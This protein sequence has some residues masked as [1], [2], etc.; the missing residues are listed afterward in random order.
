MTDGARPGIPAGRYAFRP[1]NASA[2]PRRRLRL[3]PARRG[4]RAGARSSRATPRRLLVLDRSR[5]AALQHATFREHRLSGCGRATCW[6]STTLASSRPACGG[7][8][9]GGGAAEVLR[10]ATAARGPGPMGGAGAT[11][12]PPSGRRR[13]HAAERRPAR[14][15][16]AA[17]P[18]APGPSGSTATHTPSWPPP[19]RCRCRRTSTT[20]PRLPIAT[21]PSTRSRPARPRRRPPASTSRRSSWPRWTPMA[22]RRASAS[23]STSGSTR[24]GRSRASS[25]TS[26]T[27]TASGTRCPPPPATR[28]STRA[29]GGRVVAVGTTAVRVLETAARTDADSGWTDLYV[30]PP[31][32]F[33]AVDA[34]VTNFHLPRSSLLLLVTAFV[35]AGM[36]DAAT[37]LEA[38]DALL[39]A[40]RAAL[41]E[42]VSVLQLRRR[43]AD[44]LT[45][46]PGRR[47][48]S[49]RPPSPRRRA[50]SSSS[51]SPIG[52][53]VGFVIPSAVR[54]RPRPSVS[55]RSMA[56][57][58]GRIAF[59]SVSG[60]GDPRRPGAAAGH[61]G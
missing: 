49:G 15:G 27:S 11:L 6:W 18:T 8:R 47:S 4:D 45:V 28:F 58:T 1:M 60:I 38:R 14:G 52:T 31:Y 9:P 51:P 44:R 37:P 32:R 36:G 26:T 10:A 5:P 7:T 54:R 46:R 48:G 50:R 61:R 3:R 33:R 24:S 57:A 16:G 43:D 13:R 56:L 34:L 19:A 41:A 22:I 55:A 17:R 39:G 53:A 2:T 42:G 29:A 30:T 21:R 59:V 25:S 20:D 12:A 40:Y 35:Q 23:R